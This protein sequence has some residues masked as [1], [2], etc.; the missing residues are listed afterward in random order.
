MYWERRSLGV[1]WFINRMKVSNN[2]LFG[3]LLWFQTSV[4]LK[5]DYSV[6]VAYYSREAFK[7][8]NGNHQFCAV[9]FQFSTGTFFIIGYVMTLGLK[10]VASSP[11]TYFC[12]RYRKTTFCSWIVPVTAWLVFSQ[13][14]WLQ[15]YCGLN[16]S[17]PSFQ[18]AS[19]VMYLIL[20]SVSYKILRQLV[21]EGNICFSAYHHG[22]TVEMFR[23][24]F[25][26]GG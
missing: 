23:V 11:F 8:R 9:I 1:L 21:R 17:Q 3:M 20:E 12:R 5:R 16:Y 24:G 7:I 18:R 25:E 26:F 13:N 2:F 22:S 19:A 4:I 14:G 10:W 15:S 6:L